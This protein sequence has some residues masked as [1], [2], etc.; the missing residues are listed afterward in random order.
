M[1][2]DATAEA[3]ASGRGVWIPQGCF[4]RPGR[5]ALWDV[6]VAAPP[7]GTANV[8]INGAGNDGLNM[9][10][11][12]QGTFGN[13]VVSGAG[14]GGLTNAMWDEIKPFPPACMLL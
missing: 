13:V 5:P 12:G 11:T 3:R 7:G 14:H 9:A 8:R 10:V 6:Q 2:G 1:Y 4:I